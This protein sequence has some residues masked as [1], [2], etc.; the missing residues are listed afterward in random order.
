[1]SRESRRV[2][3][4]S[5]PKLRLI[6]VFRTL[7]PTFDPNIG[8]KKTRFTLNMGFNIV[9]FK[10]SPYLYFSVPGAEETSGPFERQRAGGQRDVTLRGHGLARQDH[11]GDRGRGSAAGT[12]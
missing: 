5:S 3:I 12:Q 1:M 7:I 2:N 9:P 4:E 10:V 11:K 8:S 6:W